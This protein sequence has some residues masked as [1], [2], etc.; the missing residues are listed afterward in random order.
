MY[1]T[2]IYVCSQIYVIW[3]IF[4][5]Q[6]SYR[7]KLKEI[8]NKFPENLSIFLLSPIWAVIFLVGRIIK[9]IKGVDWNGIKKKHIHK[10]NKME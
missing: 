4:T 7:V 9:I 3:E 8:Y 10:T 5:F 6:D 2:L 1:I